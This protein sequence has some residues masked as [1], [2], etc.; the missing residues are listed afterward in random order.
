MAVLGALAVWAAVL[1]G[2]TD[3]EA[4]PTSTT[5]STVD[6]DQPTTTLPLRGFEVDDNV[7]VW[8][9]DLEPS[10]LHYDHPD[11][12]LAVAGWIRQPLLE[13]LY[14]VSGN[15]AY[16]PELLAED[17]TVVEQEDGS[18]VI[19]LVFRDDLQWSNGD[20]LTTA[21]LLYT[22]DIWREGCSLEADGTIAEWDD[23]TYQAVDRFGY[24]LIRT[25]EAASAT[26]AQ[27]VMTRFY[28]G[29]QGLFGELFHP[30]FGADANEV[31]EHL[32]RWLDAD[33]QPLVSSGPLV[34]SEWDSGMSITLVRNDRYH[35][36]VSPDARNH[37]QTSVDG[38]FIRFV[39]NVE[40]VAQAIESR[41]AH[42]L[43]VDPDMSVGTELAADA[44]FTI[45]SAGGTIYEHWG[46]NL[47]NPHLADPAV[48]EAIAYAIDKSA[49][50]EQ[51]YEPL[52][53][54]LL[55]RAGLGNTYWMTDQRAYED[56][57]SAYAGAQTDRARELLETAGY[58]AGDD[59][60]YEHPA[61]GRLTLRVGTT[62]GND[63]RER[64][65]ALLASQVSAAGIEIVADNIEG[66][67]YFV[68]Q[69]FAADALLASMTQGER[70]DPGVWD[71]AQFAWAGGPSP[72]SNSENYRS[73]ASTNPYGFANERFDALADECDATVD[74][75]EQA[76]CFN[77]LDRYLTTLE[78][79]SDGLVVVPLTQRPSLFGYT[80]D[81]VT[82]VGLASDA[83][84][85]GPL[86]NIVDFRFR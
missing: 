76:L 66:D 86:V 6:P 1:A 64:E 4:G 31:N 85:A 23:C 60:V 69:P 42:V 54:N 75:L 81:V 32:D 12:R 59:G 82:G 45:A 72:G 57:Q 14:G 2:C 52:F 71:V 26:E 24:D 78:Q 38:V 40:Q 18:V 7:L 21:D 65:Q 9:H 27:I 84:A 63:L 47:L 39:A 49:V 62:G 16:Y 41:Q 83:D 68:A 73:G 10:S 51:L 30:S 70:G 19:E 55:P 56:H 17:A 3:S 67:D 74:P 50:I 53:G 48:R 22:W 28:A 43:M 29:W 20:R 61:R 35:G 44:G 8:A 11:H 34:F 25:V 58:V 33:G 46:F 77:E 5:S 13:G 37:S 15:S 36:S 80:S 79:G